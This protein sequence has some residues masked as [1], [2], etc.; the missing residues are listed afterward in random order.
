[1]H[2]VLFR[3]FPMHVRTWRICGIVQLEL[4]FVVHV[5]CIDDGRLAPS[6]RDEQ[7]S[8]QA[9]HTSFVTQR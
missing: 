5:G 8:R 1:M 6:V 4:L 7:L 9:R 2:K 3:F